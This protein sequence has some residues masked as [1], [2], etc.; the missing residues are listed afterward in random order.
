MEEDNDA[1]AARLR[2][3]LLSSKKKRKR[4]SPEA[5]PYRRMD[6]LHGLNAPAMI[7]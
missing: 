5:D 6:A 4:A 7:D 2:E 1:K 3:E